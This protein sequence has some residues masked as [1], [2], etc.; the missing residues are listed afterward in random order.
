[1]HMRAPIP[2]GVGDAI[3]NPARPANHQHMLAGKIGIVPHRSS[4]SLSFHLSKRIIEFAA[5]VCQCRK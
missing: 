3:A 2:K 5:G 1:M 4:H